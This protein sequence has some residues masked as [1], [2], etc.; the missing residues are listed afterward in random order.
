VSTN[1]DLCTRQSAAGATALLV[2]LL[3]AAGCVQQP[4]P[5]ESDSLV[6][7]LGQAAGVSERQ[8]QVSGTEL[9]ERIR[10]KPVRLSAD[11]GR[12]LTWVSRSV[13][14]EYC[15]IVSP[16]I[17]TKSVSASCVPESQVRTCGAW[18]STVLPLGDTEQPLRRDTYLI[19]DGYSVVKDGGATRMSANIYALDRGADLDAPAVQILAQDTNGKDIQIGQVC[20]KA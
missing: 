19:P 18:L 8:P 14:E 1:R 17:E 11:D 2:V 15:I 5:P 4:Q 3:G 16:S 10:A 13:E 6:A 9:S 20:D 12:Y 7:V